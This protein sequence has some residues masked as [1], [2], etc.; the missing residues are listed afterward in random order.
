MQRAGSIILPTPSKVETVHEII[1][2]P[3]LSRFCVCFYIEESLSLEFLV[4][5]QSNPISE[6]RTRTTGC[7]TGLDQRKQKRQALTVHCFGCH[8]N[9][10]DS[11]MSSPLGPTH[12]CRIVPSKTSK[13]L[14]LFPRHST[15]MVSLWLKEGCNAVRAESGPEAAGAPP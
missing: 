13:L 14:P 1:S 7:W 10:N 2:K 9:K 8:V 3:D 5:V 6:L 11:I 4:Q 12:N 15:D